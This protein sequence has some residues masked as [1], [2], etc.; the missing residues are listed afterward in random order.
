MHILSGYACKIIVDLRFSQPSL[1]TTENQRTKLNLASS[2]EA[3]WESSG[4]HPS[5]DQSIIGY[6][7]AASLSIKSPTNRMNLPRLERFPIHLQELYETA[8]KGQ[9]RKITR[10][11]RKTGLSVN[12]NAVSLIS[13]TIYLSSGLSDMREGTSS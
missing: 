6:Y 11:V 4:C 9:G 13:G 3:E 12:D 5:S 2:F 8:E 1:Y 7:L 10:R